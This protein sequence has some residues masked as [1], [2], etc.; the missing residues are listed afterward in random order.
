MGIVLPI[1]FL[2]CNCLYIAIY[3]YTKLIHNV[4]ALRM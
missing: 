2:L 4:L 1:G 3:V